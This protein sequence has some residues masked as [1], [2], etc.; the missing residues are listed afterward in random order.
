MQELL[1]HERVEKYMRQM[2]CSIKQLRTPS[3]SQKKKQPPKSTLQVPISP[4]PT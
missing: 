4:S 1:E 3:P 2:S